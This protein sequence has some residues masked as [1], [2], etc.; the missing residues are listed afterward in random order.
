M[1]SVFTF[2]IQSPVGD[3]GQFSGLFHPH[4]TVPQSKRMGLCPSEPSLPPVPNTGAGSG[5]VCSFVCTA[6]RGCLLAPHQHHVKSGNRSLCPWSQKLLEPSG[7]PFQRSSW[8][9]WQKILICQVWCGE[10]EEGAFLSAF[11]GFRVPLG[12]LPSAAPSRSSG[13]EFQVQA[14]CTDGKFHQMLQFS[15]W[16]WKA[17]DRAGE[18]GKKNKPYNY[19]T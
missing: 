1:N 10:R 17:F 11:P 9:L 5:A 15:A 3:S 8:V 13:A 16:K 7:H 18:R 12:I 14:G 4:Y 6:G 19:S 2:V